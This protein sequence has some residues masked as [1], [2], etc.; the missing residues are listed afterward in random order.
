MSFLIFDPFTT[1]RADIHI[2]TG[3]TY[4]TYFFQEWIMHGGNSEEETLVKIY[5][6]PGECVHTSV[7][8]KVLG[9]RR[10]NKKIIFFSVACFLLLLLLSCG[11]GRTLVSLFY[12]FLFLLGML[13]KYEFFFSLSVVSSFLQSIFSACIK[14][15]QEEY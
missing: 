7:M 5:N 4:N 14:W 6:G 1:F 12:Y 10:K 9:K 13:T 2:I 3:Y 8:E 11:K 15:M